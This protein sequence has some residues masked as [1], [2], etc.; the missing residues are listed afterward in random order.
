MTN[1]IDLH[2]LAG[3]DDAA[4]PYGFEEFQRRRTAAERRRGATVWSIA[5]AVGVL[6]M[7]GLVALLTQRPEAAAVLAGA[8]PVHAAA[9][10]AA[11]P[12]QPALVDMGQFAVTSELEDHIALLDEQISA[13]RVYAAPPEQLRQLEY[14][15]RQLN[16]SLQRVSYAQTL[17]DF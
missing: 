10:R 2:E 12:Y 1:S 9:A 17:L 3:A 13:A 11:T 5:A 7:V 6:G 8:S 16:D 15:R 4:A 14:T